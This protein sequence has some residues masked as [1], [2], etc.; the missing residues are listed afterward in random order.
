EAQ[1][2][3][4]AEKSRGFAEAEINR[5]K[6]QAEADVIRTR[7][8]A[9]AEIIRAKGDS[10]AE[11]MTVKANAYSGY[12]QAAIL[13]RLLGAM[14]ELA[15]AMS[16]PLSK[17]DKITIVSTGG[18]G[19]G[20]GFPGGRS[21]PL[22]LRRAV[23]DSCLRSIDGYVQ[24]SA[25]SPPGVALGPESRSFAALRMTHLGVC[26]DLVLGYNRTEASHR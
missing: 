18:G 3:A 12:N 8:T 1:G 21:H 15:R 25:G 19:A 5:A 17:V 6:G 4:E 7:G 24:D 11:A 14:P 10:E 16:E 13:D 20:T 23:I 2:R 9:E 22:W 26:A